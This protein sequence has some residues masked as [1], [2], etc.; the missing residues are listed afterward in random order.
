MKAR[1]T[2]TAKVRA[3]VSLLLS[4]LGEI[5]DESAYARFLARHRLV[6]SPATYAAF[7]RENEI[8]KTRRVRCC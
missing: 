2:L 4:T 3:A 7:V 1:S 6:S 5:F 8:V